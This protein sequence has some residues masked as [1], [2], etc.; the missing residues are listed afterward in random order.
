ML[1]KGWNTQ[2]KQKEHTREMWSSVR[3]ISRLQW[4]L[5]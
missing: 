1:S 5:Q 3:N 2:G 4:F